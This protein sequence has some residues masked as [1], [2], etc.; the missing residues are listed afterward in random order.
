MPFDPSFYLMNINAIVEEQ[1]K[2]FAENRTLDV[3]TRLEALDRLKKMI[4]CHEKELVMALKSDLGKSETEAYMTEIG[5]ILSEITYF[6][7]HLR[8]WARPR[9]KITPL[10]N[11]PA[12]SMLMK[13]PYGVVLI[14]SP[15]NYPV[16]LA[17]QP[18]IGAIAAGNCAVIKP[19]A[20][21]PET[22]KVLARLIATTFDPRHV[23]L[24]M[25]GRAENTDLLEQKF[26]YIFFTG[27]TVVGRLV[28]EKAAKHLTPITLELGGKSPCY[29]DSHA[30]L[31]MAA[32]RLVFGKFLN[33]GQT[34][35]AP[36]YVLVHKDVH[37]RFIQLLKEET[38]KM[39]GADVFADPDYGKIVNAKHFDRITHL[40][41][42]TKVVYGGRRCPETLR[43]E[44]TILDQ[45]SPED[46]VMQEEIFGPVLP[47]ISVEDIDDAIHFIRKRPKPLALYLFTNE[48]AVEK[49]FLRE[50]SFGGGCVNDTIIHL[51]THNLP[52]GGVGDSGMGS[53]HGRRSFDTFSHT[54]SIVRK[55]IRVDLPMRYR[56]YTRMKSELIRFFLK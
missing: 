53:Y 47:V 20:Y 19:S 50:V 28:M 31:R 48:R 39:Y 37:D 3:A 38:A 40:I 51:A 15:W 35:V 22:S 1:R 49:R 23:T 33:C 27:G 29:V 34:C 21:S 7:K 43:I 17:I 56:P 18:L 2:Y 14:M 36:D 11:F 54:K 24:V 6:G 13:E 30:S 16:L 4:V 10:S 9:H 8:T 41:D 32:K 12:K 44:P 45:V 52:F 55:C 26:D 25:G 42:P 5:M 46:A